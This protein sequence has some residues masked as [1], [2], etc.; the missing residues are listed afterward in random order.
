[1]DVDKAKEAVGVRVTKEEE[2]I[3]TRMASERSVIKPE[4]CRTRFRSLH[5]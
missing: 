4:E 1:M 2:E 5:G 3:D